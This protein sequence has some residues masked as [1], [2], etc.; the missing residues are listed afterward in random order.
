VATGP[1]GDGAGLVEP[2]DLANADSCYF[3]AAYK[4][5]H[6]LSTRPCFRLYLVKWMN[7]ALLELH[8][9]LLPSLTAS[10]SSRHCFQS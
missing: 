7:S 3:L 1:T 5:W 9:Q 6:Y 10:A 4:P 8:F 2:N